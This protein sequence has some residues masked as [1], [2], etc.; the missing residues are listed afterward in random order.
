MAQFY[1][2]NANRFVYANGV[3]TVVEPKDFTGKFF[4]NEESAKQVALA[5]T[6]WTGYIF[7]VKTYEKQYAEVTLS[8]GLKYRC[9]NNVIQVYDVHSY[10]WVP[11]LHYTDIEDIKKLNSIVENPLK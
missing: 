10:G 1:V 6:E 4:D 11:S 2:Q 3:C 5:L 9:V 8:G 7:A